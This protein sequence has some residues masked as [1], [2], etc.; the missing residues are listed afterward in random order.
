V[1]DATVSDIFAASNVQQ[2]SGVAGAAADA[3]ELG[4]INKYRDIAS[5]HIF[6]PLAFDTFGVPGSSTRPILKDV[7]NRLVAA[8]HERRAGEYLLQRISLEI[9]KG[10]TISILGTFKDKSPEMNELEHLL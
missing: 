3:A 9:V 6:A 8:T 2:A 7:C 1:W 4:K 10:N 5:T